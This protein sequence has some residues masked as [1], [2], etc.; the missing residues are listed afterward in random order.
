[1]IHTWSKTDGSRQVVNALTLYALAKICSDSDS[2]GRPSYTHCRTVNDGTRSSV[3]D[4]TTPSA[5]SDTTVPSNE[6]LE[7]CT[8][9]TS[10]DAVTRSNPAT[11]AA[12]PWLRSPDPCVPV[13]HAPTTLMCGSEARFGTARP[14]LS[15]AGT[16]WP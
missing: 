2:A 15:S 1:M 12:S 13:A 11:E 6:S 16:S 3:T 10:P 4:V 9:T 8:V 7:R 5:P 14:A